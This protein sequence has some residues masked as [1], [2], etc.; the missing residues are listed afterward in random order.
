MKLTVMVWSGKKEFDGTGWYKMVGFDVEWASG[1]P[2]YWS[3]DDF[4]RT[5]LVGADWGMIYPRSSDWSFIDTEAAADSRPPLGDDRYPGPNCFMLMN[6]PKSPNDH[7][8]ANGDVVLMYTYNNSVRIA[9]GCY[10]R[11]SLQW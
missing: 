3:T 7:K 8:H 11:W 4:Y 2:I 9:T 5:L 6:P 1:K 10:G